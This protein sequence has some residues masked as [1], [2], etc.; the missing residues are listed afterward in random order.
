MQLVA[1]A[2]GM[3]QSAQGKF[4]LGIL[5]RNARHHLRALRGRYGVH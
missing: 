4:G 1:V 3:Q 2:G 5:A